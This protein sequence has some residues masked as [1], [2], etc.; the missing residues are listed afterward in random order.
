[1]SFPKLIPPESVTPIKGPKGRSLHV[2]Q[3]LREL[4]SG[5]I[6]L[7]QESVDEPAILTKLVEK[8]LH[9]AESWQIS[10]DSFDHR[11]L[12]ALII[13]QAGSTPL[14]ILGDETGFE[15]QLETADASVDPPLAAGTWLSQE[16]T[17]WQTTTMLDLVVHN[18]LLRDD[19][20]V[21]LK[22]I[23]Q[24]PKFRADLEAAGLSRPVIQS[25]GDYGIS[26]EVADAPNYMYG[27]SWSVE[28]VEEVRDD[29]AWRPIKSVEGPLPGSKIQLG[30][31]AFGGD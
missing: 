6:E 25:R 24:S 12:P 8:G 14:P 2:K 27:H 31:T 26:Q 13:T 20:V 18:P 1:M 9:L 28:F 10:T 15:E 21:V 23:V 7:L 16:L 22:G 5:Y 11:N 19:L 17:Q 3:I 29:T 30:S 4:V